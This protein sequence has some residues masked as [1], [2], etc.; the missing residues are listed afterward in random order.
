MFDLSLRSL[1]YAASVA[2]VSFGLAR[3]SA[4]AIKDIN[5][6]ISGLSRKQV[7]TS[8]TTLKKI[9]EVAKVVFSLTVFFAGTIASFAANDCLI[10]H[11]IASGYSG[12]LTSVSALAL[13]LLGVVGSA[14]ASISAFS[15]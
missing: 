15:P 8:S 2:V 11:L 10:R 7:P 4:K 9:Y 5:E 1:G 6:D 13:C 12:H 14:K 3:L